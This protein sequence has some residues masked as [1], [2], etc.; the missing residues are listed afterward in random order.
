MLLSALLLALPGGVAVAGEPA[1]KEAAPSPIYSP[2]D[3]AGPKGVRFARLVRKRNGYAVLYVRVFAPGRLVLKGRGV[4]RLARGAPR[5]MVVRLPV[6]PKVRLRHWL[7]R[8]G[9]GRIRVEVAFKSTS[10]IPH[11]LEK[12]IVLRRKRR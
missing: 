4:R 3:G 9:K 11:T 12:V 2:V 1:Y 7:K 8:R 10:G 5:A 6:K